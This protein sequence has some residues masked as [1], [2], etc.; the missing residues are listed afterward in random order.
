MNPRPVPVQVL[1][2]IH[3]FEGSAGQFEPRRTRD[4]VGNWEIGWS[5]KLD[6]PTDPLWSATL[7]AA[8][9]EAL[10]LKDLGTIAQAVC[11]TLGVAVNNLDACQYG[12]V[13][14]FAYNAGVGN[15]A[16]ST[17]CHLIKMD[18]LDEAVL[19]F[20]KWVYGHV[21]GVAVKENGLVRRRTAEVALWNTNAPSQGQDQ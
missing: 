2:I 15:F 3:Q 19:E 17:L 10:A 14:D 13:I 4:P 6:G 1:D 5:H 20:P 21:N 7:D 8:A 9:A 18:D 11:D 16:A 12:A